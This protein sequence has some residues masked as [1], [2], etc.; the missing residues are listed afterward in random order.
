MGS[1][2]CPGCDCIAYNIH[3]C[4]S[5]K[6][7]CNCLQYLRL[8]SFQAGDPILYQGALPKDEDGYLTILSGSVDVVKFPVDSISFIKL[9]QYAKRCLYESARKLLLDRTVLATLET[10]A[11]FGRV[12]R[13]HRGEKGGDNSC[14]YGESSALTDVLIISKAP[15]VECLEHRRGTHEKRR[16]LSQRSH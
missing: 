10:N 14:V 6:V 5:K 1:A 13:P 11:G 7:I 12:I 4:S 8:E 3:S 9:Q 15:F 16:Q 2:A